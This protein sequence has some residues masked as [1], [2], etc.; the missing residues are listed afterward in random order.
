M[1][2]KP[3]LPYSGPGILT[4]TPVEAGSAHHECNHEHLLIPECTN[5]N[6]GNIHGGSDIYIMTTGIEQPT[7]HKKKEF[8]SVQLTLGSLAV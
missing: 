4:G 2:Y 8:I 7:E 6:S 1:V 5:G 3:P